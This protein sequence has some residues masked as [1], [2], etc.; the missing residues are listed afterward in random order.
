VDAI[1]S[2]GRD[3]SARAQSSVTADD[4]GQRDDAG[5]LGAAIG[6]NIGAIDRRAVRQE[7]VPTRRRALAD[8]RTSSE[9]RWPR[10]ERR[11]RKRVAEAREQP[12]NLHLRCARC[13]RQRAHADA[14]A[15]E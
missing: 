9:A 15:Q 1:V 13:E 4:R 2:H 10:G 3:V 6:T 11:R 8:S 7:S 12:V 14:T 5:L